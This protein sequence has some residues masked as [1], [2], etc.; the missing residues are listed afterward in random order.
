VVVAQ[1][2]EAALARDHGVV[3]ELASARRA[4]RTS[5]INKTKL[6]KER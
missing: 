4:H 6:D 5:R 1:R 3:A 2:D